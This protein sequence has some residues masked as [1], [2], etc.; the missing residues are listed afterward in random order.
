MKQ[1]RKE[2]L[3]IVVMAVGFRLVVFLLSVIFMN[4]MGNFENGFSW[5]LVLDNWCRW[6]SPHYID[7]AR[8]GYRGAVENG[9]HLF[10]VFYPL[11][12]WCMRLVHLLIADYRV[13]GLLVNVL[14]YAVGCLYF[15]RLTEREYDSETAKYG[16]L[17]LSLF[18][19]GFFFGAIHTESLFLLISS[20]FLYYLRQHRWVLVVFFG[21]LACLTKTQGMLLAVAVAF[22]LFSSEQVIHRVKS[23]D[24]QGIVKKILLPGI[25]CALMLLGFAVYLGINRYV[26][27]DPFRFLYYQK[28]HW[29]N[30]FSPLWRAIP[31]V[32]RYLKANLHT[33]V[34]MCIWIPYMAVFLLWTLWIIYGIKEKMRSS[35][36]FY[37]VALFF[38]TFSLSWPIS[39]SRYTLCAVPGFMLTGRFLSKHGRLRIPVLVIS[40]MLMTIY[41]AGFLSGKQIM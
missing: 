29:Y 28:N 1:R 11:L 2:A 18:P 25:F 7:I 8:L 12:P 21:F 31:N 24:W 5:N 26:E 27:G 36:F 13:C 22:E 20:A 19:F 16:V 33:S 15:Y 32:L 10:L 9:E 35:Y 14:C 38:V 6:D 39:S 37:M 4:I 34:G 3:S 23:K 41:M 40:S 30:E 17:S